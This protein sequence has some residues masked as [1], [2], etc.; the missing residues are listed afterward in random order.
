[1]GGVGVAEPVG[2]AAP[3]HVLVGTGLIGPAGVGVAPGGAEFVGAGAAGSV[4]VGAAVAVAVGD[5][6]EVSVGAA[7]G[8]GPPMIVAPV[9]C[10]ARGTQ[11]AALGTGKPAMSTSPR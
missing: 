5:G 3:V 8:P 9:V 1:M 10:L 11:R 6:I 7:D 4:G 2:S